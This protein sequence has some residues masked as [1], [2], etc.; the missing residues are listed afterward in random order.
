MVQSVAVLSLTQ[1]QWILNSQCISR[2]VHQL[3]RVEHRFWIGQPHVMNGLL[4]KKL[5][6]HHHLNVIQSW[7]V[8]DGEGDVVGEQFAQVH[9]RRCL[10]VEPSTLVEQRSQ[11]V[12]VL[13]YLLVCVLENVED[14]V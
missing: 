5:R 12:D 10:H 1:H 9:V 2:L 11:T 13:L 6:L 3:D 7:L 8:P 4:F 14:H